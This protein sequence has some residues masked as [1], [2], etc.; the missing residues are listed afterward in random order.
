MKIHKAARIQFIAKIAQFNAMKFLI[1]SDVDVNTIAYSY[2]KLTILQNAVENRE[3]E[4]VKFFLKASV[5]VNIINDMKYN[6]TAREIAIRY[7]YNTSCCL[8]RLAVIQVL[9]AEE[10]DVNIPDKE[11][12]G[13]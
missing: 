13:T 8:Q 1:L 4:I 5:D 3:I 11:Q 7:V 6:K 12:I 10:A 2:N 9:L